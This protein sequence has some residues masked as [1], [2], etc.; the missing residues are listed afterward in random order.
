MKTFLL[1]KKHDDNL[2]PK[3]IVPELANMKIRI[4][5]EEYP[6]SGVLYFKGTVRIFLFE[7]KPQP[8]LIN[9]LPR[10]LTEDR[11]TYCLNTETI[12]IERLPDSDK[13]PTRYPLRTR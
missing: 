6:E 5:S 11:I 2:L 13:D 9:M 3:T 7:R 4:C 12:V 10:L 1:V 8:V